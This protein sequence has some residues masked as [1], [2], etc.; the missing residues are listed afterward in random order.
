MEK[1]K[2]RSEIPDKYKWDLTK[3]FKNEEEIE[4][5]IEEIKEKC[6]ALNKY[7]G[8]L[9]ESSKNLYEATN[10]QF[11]IVRILDR[12]VV[13]SN[14]LYHEDMANSNSQELVGKISKLEDFVS[15]NLSFY[16]PELLE[17]SYDKVLDY[18]KENKNLETYAFMFED[19]FREK[20][21][22][23]SAKEE[24]MLA[25]LGEVFNASSDTYESLD[26]VDLV[27][28]DILDEEN[29]K[30]ALNSS[31]FTRY[32]KSNDR[33]VRRDTFNSFYK[34]YE[35][36]KHTFTQTLKGSINSDTFIAKIRKYNSALEYAL[37]NNNID[38]S[39]YQKLCDKIENNLEPLHKYMKVKKEMLNLDEMHMYDIYVPLVNSCD[40]K[41]SYEEAKEITLDALKPLGNTYINDL[42]N[43]FNSNC[44]DV[45]N[46]K[47]KHSGAYSWGSYDTLPYVLLNFEGTFNDVSTIAHELGHSMHSYYSHKNQE[48]HNANYTIFL[49]EIASTVNEIFLS[50]Y[51]INNAKTKEEKLFYL[52]NI[53]ENFRTTLYRQTMFAHFEKIIHEK[54]ENGEVLT[55]DNLS[56]TYLELNKKY[57]GNDIISDEYISYEW[58]RI[59]HFYNAFYVYKYATGISIASRIVNDI[60]ENKENAKE[61]YLKFLASGGSDYSLNILKNVGIDI[62]NDDTIDIAIKMFND[63]LE[64]FIKVMNS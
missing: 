2:L 45:Y 62:V 25:S 58:M 12:L 40:K 6:I 23:L 27:F 34:G 49:A 36:Y 15:V 5:S 47:N 20:E 30:V 59:S 1:I 14:M 11:E 17:S 44:I 46:N 54:V 10:L 7:K 29:N 52:N 22:T 38:I 42:K 60:L 50:K 51:A 53:L 37:S 26:D 55:P 4:K 8:S 56:Q 31:N 48:Y 9:M 16:T 19:L 28:D 21:H 13:Y 24:S 33:R 18:I 39:L 3:I 64:E 57:Y 32:I 63:T 43:I 41:Y 61:N 35:L